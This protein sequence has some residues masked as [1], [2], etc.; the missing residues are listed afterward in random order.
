MKYEIENRVSKSPLKTIDIEDFIVN[1]KIEIFDIKNCLKD[2]FILIEKDFRKKVISFDW[3]IYK[4]V[5]VSIQCT[6]NAIVPH[7]AFLLISSELKKLNIKNFIGSISDFENHLINEAINLMDLSAYHN[8]SVIIKG[9]SNKVFKESFYSILIDKL[10]P[11]VKS[12]MFGE[13]CSSVPI[14]KKRND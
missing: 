1:S 7:W 5:F 4:K 2:E 10:Q 8:K 9:C 11:V 3:S 12:I 13:A 14:Y 6:N